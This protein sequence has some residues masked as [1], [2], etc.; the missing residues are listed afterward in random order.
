MPVEATHYTLQSEGPDSGQAALGYRVVVDVPKSSWNKPTSPELFMAASVP[1][2]NFT[3]L[4]GWQ[5]HLTNPELEVT[6]HNLRIRQEI[7]DGKGLRWSRYWLVVLNVAIVVVLA[8]IFMR[9]YHR[10]HFAGQG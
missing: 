6:Q 5:E 4:G 1:E 10:R 7:I 8:A 9:R 3:S 2:K